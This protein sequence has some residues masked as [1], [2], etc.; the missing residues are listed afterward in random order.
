MSSSGAPPDTGRVSSILSEILDKS[1]DTNEIQTLL[2]QLEHDS[3]PIFTLNLLA[4]SLFVGPTETFPFSHKEALSVLLILATAD[5]R[6]YL[7]PASRAVK[8]H[9]EQLPSAV[10]KGKDV[11]V[12]DE[13]LSVLIAQLSGTDVEVSSNA[14]DALRAC[15]LALGPTFSDRAIGSI[16]ESWKTV[17]AR[18]DK[19]NEATTISVRCAS[20]VVEIACLHDASMESAVSSGS[21]DLLLTMMTDNSDPLL[22]MSTLDLFERLATAHPMHSGRSHW[23]FSSIVLHPLLVMAGQEESPDPILGGPALRLLSRICRLSQQDETLFHLGGNELLTGFHHA[24]RNFDVSSELERL[25]LIDAVSSFASASPD[26]LEVVLE[27]TEVRKAWLSLA[28]AQPKLKSAILHSVAQVID[29]PPEK[30]S[31]GESIITSNVPSNALA[32]KLYSTLGMTNDQDTTEMVMSLAKSPIVETRLGEY[33]LLE[34]IAKRG[35]GSQVLL[36]HGGFFEF[37]VSREGEQTKEGKEAKFA[38]VQAVMNS[39]ARGLLAD[40][41][42]ATLERILKEG[43]FYVKTQTW[44]VQTE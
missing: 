37:L 13:L 33:T 32:L 3:D 24:L 11:L 38:I 14:A 26:A 6:T 2:K 30:D 22:Q 18:T 16:L 35:T 41:I 29:P 1:D 42:V 5:S 25:A 7:K 23:L 44:E 12:T 21:M 36:S 8:A 9:A 17:W 43:P 27:D 34:A 39:E 20:A 15:A 40:N 28:V 19:R 10:S 31:N 4:P